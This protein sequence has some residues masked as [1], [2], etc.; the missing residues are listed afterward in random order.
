MREDVW[1]YVVA[2]IVYILGG[3]L[4]ILYWGAVAAV[5]IYVAKWLFGLM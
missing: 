1:A 4:K 5:V 3:V 2:V